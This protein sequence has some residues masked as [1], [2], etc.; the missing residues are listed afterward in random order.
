MPSNPVRRITDQTHGRR[1]RQTSAVQTAS[2]NPLHPDSVVA[3]RSV[4]RR[5]ASRFTTR[6]VVPHSFRLCRTTSL[7]CCRLSPLDEFLDLATRNN[8][9]PFRNAE[10]V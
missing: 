6:S 5:S 4:A 9:E 7:L 2:T 3:A 10:I 1:E 8:F